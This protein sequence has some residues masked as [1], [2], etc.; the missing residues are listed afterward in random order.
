[1][2]DNLLMV[3]EAA[4]RLGISTATF[5]GWLAQSNAGTLR[6]RGQPVTVAYF[7]GG[8]Q[9]QGR[10]RIEAEEVVRLNELMRVQP[11]PAI[12]RALPARRQY[13]PG[14]TVKLGRPSL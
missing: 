5:Y 2:S 9:G 11:Y 7:Q 1:M 13:F 8:P 6:I 14:I 4:R 12:P 3:D 10:I